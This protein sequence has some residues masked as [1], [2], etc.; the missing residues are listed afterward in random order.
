M[1]RPQWNQA[2]RNAD[3][4]M[5]QAAKHGIGAEPFRLMVDAVLDATGKMALAG[6]NCD[7]GQQVLNQAKETVVTL[8]EMKRCSLEDVQD[9]LRSWRENDWRGHSPPTFAQIVEHASAMD[10]GTH[11]TARKQ[12]S[13]KKEFASLADYNEWAARNDPDYKR[14]R[15]GILVKGTFVRRE[16]YQPT[17]VH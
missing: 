2:K 6:T 15:E 11:R 13:G 1:R 14:I 7:L 3:Q 9:V 5:A 12:D 8:L 4:F 16:S 10:A 17:L